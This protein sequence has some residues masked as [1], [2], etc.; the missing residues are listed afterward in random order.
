LDVDIDE[1][2]AETTAKKTLMRS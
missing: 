1:D 2:A